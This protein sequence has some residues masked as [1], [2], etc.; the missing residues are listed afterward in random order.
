MSWQPI[1]TAPVETPV[2]V[3]TSG[4][5]RLRI[6]DLVDGCWWDVNEGYGLMPPTHWMPLPEP[7]K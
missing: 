2:L 1:E 7:P 6:A 3:G 5:T 4:L